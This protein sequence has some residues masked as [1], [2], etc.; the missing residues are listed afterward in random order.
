MEKKIILGLN[1]PVS[2][3]ILG[4]AK[5]SNLNVEQWFNLLDGFVGYSGNALD[6][7][8]CYGESENVIGSWS[9]ARNNRDK[10][11]FITKGALTDDNK[12]LDINKLE[13][14]LT[15]S[16]QNLKTSYVDM[17]FLH[18]D[19]PMIPVGEIMD[20]L[21]MELTKGRIRALGASNWTTRRVDEANEYAEKHNIAGFTGVSNNMSMAVAN[22]SV[23]YKNGMLCTDDQDKRWHK[24]TGI[25]L[26]AW[27]AQA[28]GFFSG[29]YRPDFLE[30]KSMVSIYYSKQNFERLRRAEE[31]GRKKNG[32]SATQIALSWLLHQDF[33]VFPVIGV[34]NSGQMAECV[35][36]LKINLTEE[37]AG[38]LNLSSE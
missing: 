7:A 26:F 17:Y 12:S 29:K 25:P 15:T 14:D 24:K 2:E 18:R 1:K 4:T 30:N 36:A 5:F 6:T 9:N 31:L 37:E 20:C 32:Y 34:G 35:K 3:L 19:N 8:R 11:F 27:S 38:W 28:Q 33:S 22:A 21:N 10:I 16:L 23:F 13:N